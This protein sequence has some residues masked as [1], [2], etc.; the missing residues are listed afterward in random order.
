MFQSVFRVILV[1]ITVIALATFG[2]VPL[3]AQTGSIHLEG[4]VWNPS[5]NPLPGAKL[6]AVEENTGQIA[7]TVSDSDG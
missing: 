6:T 4:I 3:M 5:G 2:C 1:S 7:E